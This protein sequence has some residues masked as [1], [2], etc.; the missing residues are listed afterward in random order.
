MS[1]ETVQRPIPSPGH[2]Y[3]VDTEAPPY[4]WH[5]YPACTV[6]SVALNYIFGKFVYA[7]AFRRRDATT[8]Q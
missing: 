6:L 8:L 3:S 5:V 1:S 7:H 2:F 4:R